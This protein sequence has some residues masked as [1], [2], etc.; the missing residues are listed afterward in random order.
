[1]PEHD[2]PTAREWEAA[3]ERLE[4]RLNRAER[5]GTTLDAL[6]LELGLPASLHVIPRYL[7][8]RAQAL[9][10]RQQRLASLRPTGEQRSAD[11]FTLHDRVGHLYDGP[12]EPVGFDF[13][14]ALKDDEAA[15]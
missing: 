3:L 4:V 11:G 2:T 10:E 14:G 6:D 9:V 5:M 1:M 7:L 8:A 13:F 12:R 15:G